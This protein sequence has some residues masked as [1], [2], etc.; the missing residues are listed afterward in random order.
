LRMMFRTARLAFFG[1]SLCVARGTTVDAS[2]FWVLTKRSEIGFRVA[3][4]R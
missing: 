4:A 3:R 2:G 1:R